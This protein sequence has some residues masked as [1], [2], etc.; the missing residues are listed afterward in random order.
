VKPTPRTSYPQ[1]ARLF[2]AYVNQ[3]YDVHGPDPLDAVRA[4]AAD[5]RPATRAAAAAE[6]DDLL[7]TAKGEAAL[8]AVLDALKCGYLPSAAGSTARAFLRA[9]KAVLTAR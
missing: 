4:Y 2:K 3:D 8:D 9:V 1:L 7:A 6:T 5:V